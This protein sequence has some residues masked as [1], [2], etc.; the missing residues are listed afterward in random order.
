MQERAF[1]DG[2]FY[3]RVHLTAQE[4]HD[5]GQVEPEE[6][7][8]DGAERAVGCGVTVEIVQIHPQSE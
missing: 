1:G 2:V 3:L 7:D 5:A 4:N 8:N 6:K